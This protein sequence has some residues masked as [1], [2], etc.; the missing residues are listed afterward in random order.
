MTII[1]TAKAIATAVAVVAVSAPALAADWESPP[2]EGYSW[3]GPYVGGHGGYALLDASNSVNAVAPQNWNQKADGFLGGVLVGYNF[4]MD[5][6]VLGFEA[7]AGF[8]DINDRETRPGIGGVKITHHGQHT[9]RLRGG[10][11]Y[12]PALFYATGGLALADFRARSPIGNDKDFFFGFTVGG[13][14]EAKITENWSLRAEYLYGNYGRETLNLGA[15][16]VRADFETH[17]FRVGFAWHFGHLL[18]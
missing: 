5:G 14:V 15:V 7:D 11:T 16:P 10:V 17:N 8:G 3:E 6:Y 9:F 2:A 4:D 13:G 1:R 18:P 12:G